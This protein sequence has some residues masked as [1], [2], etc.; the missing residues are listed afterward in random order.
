M[1]LA[2]LKSTSTDLD[3]PS[4]IADTAADRKG[5]P[6]ARNDSKPGLTTMLIDDKETPKLVSEMIERYPRVVE[7][8]ERIELERTFK[9]SYYFG[10]LVVALKST[11]QGPAIAYSGPVEEVARAMSK[12]TRRESEQLTVVMPDPIEDHVQGLRKS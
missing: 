8:S 11:R 5:S 3:S 2:L 4:E 12:L 1:S 9:L 10:G 6:T 7:G